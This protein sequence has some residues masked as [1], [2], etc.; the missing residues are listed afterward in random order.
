VD[1]AELRR[2]RDH[3]LARGP[4]GFGEWI[5]EDRRM[6]F[7]H[8]RLSFLDL[9]KNGAQPMFSEDRKIVITFNGEIYNYRELRA[10]LEMQNCKFKSQSDT[11]VILQMYRFYGTKMIAKLRGM[12]AF[13]LWDD[14]RKLLIIAR[15]PYGIKPLYY[16]DTPKAFRFASSVKAL[17]ASGA[18]SREPEPAGIVGF[19]IFGSVPEPWTTYKA[20]K[21]LPAGTY[22]EVSTEGIGAPKS[23]FSIATT[24][25]E[26]ENA[27]SD[28]AE[29]Q[30][31]FRSTVLDSVRH[32]LVSDVPIGAFLSSGVDSG[33]LV[34]LMRDAGQNDIRTITLS[35]NSFAGKP[36][37][38][39][40]LARII[41]NKYGTV[42]TTRNVDIKEFH[43]DLPK[44]I[45]AMDQ[46]SIDGINT[47][48]VSKA[49][50]ELGLKAA[51][52]GVGGDELLGGYSTFQRLPR[53]INLLR[54]LPSMKNSESYL[55]YVVG[56]LRRIGIPIHPKMAGLFAYSNNYSGAYLLQRCIF[57]PSELRG[58]DLDMTMLQQG[59]AELQP[60]EVVERQLRPQPKYAFSNISTLESSLYLRNQLLR[61][62]DWAGMAHSVEIRTPL[63]DSKLLT[64]LA[65]HFARAKPPDGKM[66][67]ANSP[68]DPLPDVV[69]QRV[70]TGF[71]IPI[72][73][74]YA[75]ESLNSKSDI[76]AYDGDRLW[77]RIWMKKILDMFGQV[78]LPNKATHHSSLID[79]ASQF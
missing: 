67:L 64:D 37:D 76:T 31:L 22:A 12:F 73:T 57:L 18:I 3:M 50:H 58:L 54:L 69:M 8:R 11:E 62:T 24:Y 16:C 30:A 4:D 15:D 78:D 68:K 60:L 29:L 52:S 28:S 42:H 13:G 65:P 49:T 51:I 27:T 34:G 72:R 61:D 35:F 33:A 25:A 38:E 6:G 20:I 17:L 1:P 19:E 44:I 77:S 47:W 59:L 21:S 10:D 40:P 70:K 63:V 9:S 39:A 32:H 26:A 36:E 75:S 66:L 2:T 41:A 56:G 45:S 53:I 14:D 74:W 43:S 5:S 7:G 79:D 55:S 48:F 46:P 23:F 71:G